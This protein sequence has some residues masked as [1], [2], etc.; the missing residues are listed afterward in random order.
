MAISG[1]SFSLSKKLALRHADLGL[2]E[3][4]GTP[5]VHNLRRWHRGESILKICTQ[6][7]HLLHLCPDP[8]F[9]ME[10]KLPCGPRRVSSA[11]IIE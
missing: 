1:L 3:A 7:L 2:G 4:N 5:R 6:V 10:K 8:A 9:N 11:D